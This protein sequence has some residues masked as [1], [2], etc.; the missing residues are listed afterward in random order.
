MLFGNLFIGWLEA[1]SLRSVFKIRVRYWIII[2]LFLMLIVSVIV[3]WPFFKSSAEK[4]ELAVF[5]QA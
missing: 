2:L 3:E 1:F 4:L 5:Q